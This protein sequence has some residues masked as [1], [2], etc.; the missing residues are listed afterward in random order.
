MYTIDDYGYGAQGVAAQI[1]RS[2]DHTD[3]DLWIFPSTNYSRI[4][5]IPGTEDT[6]AIIFVDT[7][8]LAPS[9]NGCCNSKGYVM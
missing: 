4:F 5:E 8:T 2:R 7:T 3:D 1:Q 9:E 6:L